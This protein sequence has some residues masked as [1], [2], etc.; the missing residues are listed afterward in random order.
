[1]TNFQALEISLQVIRS[2][3][4]PVR[5]IRQCDPKLAEQIRNASSSVALNLSEGRRRAGK[6]RVY[7]WRVAGGSA[8]ETLTALRVAEAWG[9]IEVKELKVPLELLDRALA[10]LWRLTS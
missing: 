8:D 10:M 7:H 3:R 2:L 4:E 6:D 9:Y 5:R 1:M